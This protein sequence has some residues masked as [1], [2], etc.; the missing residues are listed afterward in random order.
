M[1]YSHSKNSYLSYDS[2]KP[3]PYL[4]SV[5]GLLFEEAEERKFNNHRRYL[6]TT[7]VAPSDQ[8][9]Y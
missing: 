6:T 8:N 3:L 5:H 2:L 4:L 1:S 9:E 7:S